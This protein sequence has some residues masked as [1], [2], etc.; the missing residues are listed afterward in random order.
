MSDYLSLF[1]DLLSTILIGWI[2]YL[3]RRID[4]R[5]IQ[6]SLDNA[7]LLKNVAEHRLDTEREISKLRAHHADELL[8]STQNFMEMFSRAAT[9]FVVKEDFNRQVDAIFRKLDKIE[10][11]VD[12]MKV[13]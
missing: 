10:E 3:Q 2:W 11:K 1:A 9:N 8:K 12:S 4:Q 6:C 7:E 13:H 5:D